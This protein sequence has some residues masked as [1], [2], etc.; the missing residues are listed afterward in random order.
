M[1]D[2]NNIVHVSADHRSGG[3]LSLPRDLVI[4]QPTCVDPKTKQQFAAVSAEPLNTSIARG[5]LG[6]VV[7]TVEQQTG[8]QI[9]YA[10]LF[11]FQGTVAMADAVGGVRVRATK[12]IDDPSSGLRLPAA[13]STIAGRTVLAHPRD[14]HGIGD[15]SDLGGSRLSRRT[16]RRCCGR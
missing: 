14:R 9:P 8:L 2:V 7:S 5:D 16:C 3:V 1:N 11:S 12:A 6:C 15:G 13:R 10:A 4:D